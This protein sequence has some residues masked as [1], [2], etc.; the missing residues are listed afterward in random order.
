MLCPMSRSRTRPSREDTRDRLFAAAAAV[1]VRVGIGAASVEDIALEAGLTRGALYSNFRNKDDLVMAMIDDHFERNMD[2]VERLL[3]MS[4]SPTEYLQL[5][6]S[7]QRRR[8]GPLANDAVLHMEFLLHALRDPAN[9][10]RLAAHQHR[11]REII[12][13]LVER[14][15]EV[16]GIAPPMTPAEAAEMILAMDNGYLLQQLLEPGSYREG[17]MTRHLL[18]LQRLWKA[19][20]AT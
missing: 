3:S 15:A 9:R 14:D 11:W 10:A 6:E 8:E 20:A 18:T 17:T 19:S 7:P 4:S 1:F 2:E 5:M 16:L 13:A 12:T